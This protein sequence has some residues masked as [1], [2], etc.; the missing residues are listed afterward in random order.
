MHVHPRPTVIRPIVGAVL[1]AL[2][3]VVIW[4]AVP[5]AI[6]VPILLLAVVAEVVIYGVLFVVGRRRHW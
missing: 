2:M 4:A 3:L 5:E 1:L 6:L